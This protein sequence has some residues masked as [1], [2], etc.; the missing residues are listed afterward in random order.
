MKTEERESRERIGTSGNRRGR[1]AEHLSCVLV[2]LV[3]QAHGFE[4]DCADY[5][6]AFNAKLVDR[7]LRRVPKDVVVSV[8]QIDQINGRDAAVEKWLMVIFNRKFSPE[9]M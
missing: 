7:V 6:K 5:G 9:K 2:L 3:Y 1:G 8:I 4:R